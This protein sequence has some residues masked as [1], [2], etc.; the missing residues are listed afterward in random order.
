MTTQYSLRDSRCVYL[1]AVQADDG[2]R[3]L[4]FFAGLS[5]QSRD[6]MHGWSERCTPEHAEKLVQRAADADHVSLVAI[7]SG[8]PDQFVGYCWL[9]GV[10]G[11]DMPMLGIGI[12]DAYHE[13]GLGRVLLRAML[14][15]AGSLGATQVRLGVWT[16][17]AR[18]VHVY[19]AVGF[20]DDPTM[21]AK[22][23]AGRTE[24]YMVAETGSEGK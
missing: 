17:N 7:P 12:I 23:F 6:F 4:E 24:L 11:T 15:Q 16:D 19:R 20:R 13:A 10:G 5:A 21:P 22:E 1:R 8:S 18:A 3:F 2:A 9:D 14:A